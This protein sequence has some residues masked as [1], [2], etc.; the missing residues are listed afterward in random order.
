MDI[1][2][3]PNG[4]LIQSDASENGKTSHKRFGHKGVDYNN[5]HVFYLLN[6][7]MGAWCV[8]GTAF[9]VQSKSTGVVIRACS[10]LFREV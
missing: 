10:S 4:S 5:G 1:L 3:I 7:E 8:S 9:I 2:K 6:K